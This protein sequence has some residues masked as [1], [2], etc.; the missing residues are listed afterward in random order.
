MIRKEKQ[1]SSHGVTFLKSRNR[2]IVR[3]RINGRRKQVGSF[4]TGA[5]AVRFSQSWS[6]SKWVFGETNTNTPIPQKPPHP[7]QSGSG[8]EAGHHFDRI[9]SNGNNGSRMPIKSWSSLKQLNEFL[10]TLIES[11]PTKWWS[12]TG[13]T[14]EILF[15]DVRE[16]KQYREG[17]WVLVEK[18]QPGKS[19]YFECAVLGDK[20]VYPWDWNLVGLRTFPFTTR[21]AA[22]K[23]FKK[24]LRDAK[25]AA[26][27]KEAAAHAAEDAKR[28]TRAPSPTFTR[29]W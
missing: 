25:S 27:K 13:E 21:P 3:K 16:K 29:I 23:F 1:D 22:E 26:N 14:A 6:P 11:A 2:H 24:H 9:P 8:L 5:E 18:T 7:S 17:N 19:D 12:K 15:K 20:E 4:K 10:E 28:T